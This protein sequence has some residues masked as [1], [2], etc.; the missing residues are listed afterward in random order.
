MLFGLLLGGGGVPLLLLGGSPYYLI[1]GAVVIYSAVLMWRGRR[2]G[3]MLYGL[4]MGG[5]L[6]WSVWEVGL[7]GW[8]LMPRLLLPALLGVWLLVIVARRPLS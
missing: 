8:A 7:D 1:A 4:F 2:R 5:T 3:A 6:V